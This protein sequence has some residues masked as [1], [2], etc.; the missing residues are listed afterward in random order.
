MVK[1]K[2]PANFFSAFARRVYDVVARIPRGKTMTYGEV[3]R[4]AGNPGAARAV[5]TI[6]S[7]NHNPKIPCHRVIRT[8]GTPGG[9]NRGAALK[10]Q[11]L[12]REKAYG[13]KN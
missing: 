5:G 2:Q 8:D 12:R 7:K 3:A 11:I 4:Y 9:Y 13:R 1:K 10:E 6:L